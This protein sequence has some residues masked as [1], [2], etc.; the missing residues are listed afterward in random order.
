MDSPKKPTDRGDTLRMALVVF[1]W[2][3]IWCRL[4]TVVAILNHL[5]WPDIAGLDVFQGKRLHSARWDHNHDM[6]GQ[7]ADRDA[8]IAKLKADG[9]PLYIEFPAH[10]SCGNSVGRYCAT[11]M[12]SSAL[13]R[14]QLNFCRVS[15]ERAPYTANGLVALLVPSDITTGRTRPS[16]SNW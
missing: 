2:I 8:L 12:S 14:G 16:T 4:L 11:A 9:K 13:G 10:C 15:V 5:R 1:L 6:T 7:R 3:A